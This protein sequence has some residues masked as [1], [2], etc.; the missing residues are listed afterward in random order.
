MEKIL[1]GSKLA[2]RSPTSSTQQQ[3]PAL[4]LKSPRSSLQIQPAPAPLLEPR[5]RPTSSRPLPPTP[6]K[7]QVETRTDAET[8][9]AEVP[10]QQKETSTKSES[11][12]QTITTGNT[13]LTP[14]V[15][16]SVAVIPPSPAPIQILP[17][18]HGPTAGNTFP[19]EK[20]A[21]ALSM[22]IIQSTNPHTLLTQVND[23]LPTSQTLA[24]DEPGGNAMEAKILG[25]PSEEELLF[26]A[27]FFE[28]FTGIVHDPQPNTRIPSVRNRST[29]SFGRSNQQIIPEGTVATNFALE[30]ELHPQPEFDLGGETDINAN[31]ETEINSN[32]I[33]SPEENS[34]E[35]LELDLNLLHELDIPRSPSPL[36]EIASPTQIEQPQSSSPPIDLPSQVLSSAVQEPDS[37][38]SK[39][40]F[41]A[42]HESFS[43]LGL[44]RLSSRTFGSRK[45]ELLRDGIIFVKKFLFVATRYSRFL[46]DSPKAGDAALPTAPFLALALYDYVP[47]KTDE[48]GTYIAVTFIYLQFK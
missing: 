28:R 27:Q 41:R 6:R 43:A 46:V 33:Q 30:Y 12:V 21:H 42:K 35:P 16:T 19:Q 17:V 14:T 10:I 47:S 38:A 40:E 13:A 5:A 15:N 29:T 3:T 8:Q 32:D 37:H 11:T 36:D 2:V 1:G 45:S 24:G 25:A 18:E 23:N 9:Q 31:S 4:P 22:D 26:Q 39:S 34:S 44:F 48:N 7:P 20:P